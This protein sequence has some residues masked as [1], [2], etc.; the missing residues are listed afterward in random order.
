MTKMDFRSRCNKRYPK[1]LD[2]SLSEIWVFQSDLDANGTI[3]LVFPVCDGN[4]CAIHI[5]Y[6]QQIGVCNGSGDQKCRNSDNL[7]IADPDFKLDFN[8]RAII[9][10]ENFMQ[11]RA[12]LTTDQSF[13]GILPIP[14]RL[15][16]ERLT[17]GL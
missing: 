14:L 3:D 12:I 9:P 8:N 4:E 5:V 15:G 1:V 16:M 10:F 7:C 2:K 17:R 11:H 13:Q 6:N